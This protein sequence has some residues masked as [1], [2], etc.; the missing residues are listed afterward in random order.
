MRGRFRDVSKSA[1]IVSQ[2]IQSRSCRGEVLEDSLERNQTGAVFRA[3]PSRRAMRSES[4]GEIST[5]ILL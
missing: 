2:P 1:R 4:P 5:I 3:T